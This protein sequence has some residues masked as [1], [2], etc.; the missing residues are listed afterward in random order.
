M[1][2]AK[3]CAMLLDV[4]MAIGKFLNYRLLKLARKER[5]RNSLFDVREH[6]IV[7]GRSV[8]RQS[9]LRQTLSANVRRFG[10]MAESE[11]ENM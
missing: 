3:A 9:L 11:L 2:Y 8:L 4:L 7:H 6:R 5:L 10:W 1:P